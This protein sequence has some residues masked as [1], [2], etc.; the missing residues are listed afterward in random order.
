M[1]CVCHQR[2]Y[3]YAAHPPPPGQPDSSAR[4]GVLDGTVDARRR[5]QRQGPASH[6]TVCTVHVL[7]LPCPLP[8]SS[9]DHRVKEEDQVRNESEC[10]CRSVGL[11]PHCWHG[12]LTA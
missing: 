10:C 1:C 7:F 3:G 12:V 2:G 6:G 9:P 5:R 11:A 8:A 4:K